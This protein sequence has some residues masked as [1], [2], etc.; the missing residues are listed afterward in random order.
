MKI[1]LSKES[2]EVEV[3]NLDKLVKQFD[4]KGHVAIFDNN[5]I[6]FVIDELKKKYY[7]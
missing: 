5:K 1:E 6:Y 7:V 4:I 3:A 2:I